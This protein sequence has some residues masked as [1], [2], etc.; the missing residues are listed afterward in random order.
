MRARAHAFAHA[1]DRLQEKRHD[2]RRGRAAI[3]RAL[4]RLELRARLVVRARPRDRRRRGIDLSAFDDR[5]HAAARE[6][7][8]RRVEA[9]IERRAHRGERA[10]F[11]DQ[12][13]DSRRLDFDPVSM[14]ERTRHARDRAPDRPAHRVD[15]V[16]AD[17]EEHSA[18]PRRVRRAAAREVRRIAR[19]R[20][21]RARHR[22]RS[23]HPGANRRAHCAERSP[24]A[25]LHDRHAPGK[26]RH[27]IEVGARRGHGFLHECRARGARGELG[28]RAMGD[29]RTAHARELGLDGEELARGLEH[30]RPFRRSAAAPVTT[31]V[32]PTTTELGERARAIGV[33]IED[34]DNAHARRAIAHGVKQAGRA[35]AA[36]QSSHELTAF[37]AEVLP[38]CS[39]G[40]EP[41]P[42]RTRH[43][44]APRGARALST[45]FRSRILAWRIACKTFERTKRNSSPRH[46]EARRE[47]R[48]RMVAWDS[49]SDPGRR[50]P[51]LALLG[52]GT[53]R[54]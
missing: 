38:H 26:R 39:F 1:R 33:G 42:T 19:P 17:R 21:V 31:P 8:A 37:M 13:S 29:G 53:T 22:R 54:C 49:D 23:H 45:S 14:R 15:G 35:G 24:C 9:R 30:A 4:E 12:V 46:K 43:N 16:H 47:I 40:R 41:R 27:R 25:P 11:E 34:A 48:T 18:S 6:R 36:D 7:E 10:A 32:A 3:R 52:A 20:A 2:E 28:L 51:R 5:R 44:A 50:L